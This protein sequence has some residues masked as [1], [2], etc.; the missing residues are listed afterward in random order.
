MYKVEKP[1]NLKST[2]HLNLL[3]KMISLQKIAT[4]KS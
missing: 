2:P 3:N 1:G 4:Q